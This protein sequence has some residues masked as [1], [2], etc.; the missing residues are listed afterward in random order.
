MDING[1][2]HNVIC[3]CASSSHCTSDPALLVL[4]VFLSCHPT[5]IVRCENFPSVMRAFSD[6]LDQLRGVS[7]EIE[8]HVKKEAFVFA[9]D[10]YSTLIGSEVNPTEVV[11]FLQLLTIYKITDS[12]HPD[13]LLGLLEKVQPTERVVSLVKILGLTDE[14]QCMFLSLLFFVSL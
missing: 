3:H 12:F 13:G 11:A 9:S 5:K 7:P 6:L 1:E 10:W 4:D 14:I 2:G 8:L